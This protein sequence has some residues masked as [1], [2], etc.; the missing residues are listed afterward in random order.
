MGFLFVLFHFDLSLLTVIRMQKCGFSHCYTS[1][2]FTCVE[3][4]KVFVEFFY[5]FEAGNC[6]FLS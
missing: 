1:V 5:C 2:Y 4:I 6:T 3:E